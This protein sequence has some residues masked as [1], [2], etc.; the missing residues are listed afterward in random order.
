[1]NSQ[2]TQPPGRTW[3]SWRKRASAALFALSIA[4]V[5]WSQTVTI[6]AGVNAGTTGSNAGPIYRSSA[7]SA[8]DFSQQVYLYTAAELATA[9]ILPGTTITSLAW[10]KS[11]TF[12]TTATNTVSI[13]R[14]Y[15]KNS[16][17][18]PGATWS[19]TSFPTQVSGATLVYNNT[20]QVIPLVAGY[21]TLT[22][23]TPF[24]YTGGALEIGS[25][26]DCSLFA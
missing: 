1:M 16:A 22:F 7:G 11:N 21:I 20:A 4:L 13:W 24:V 9:G 10:N 3:R 17:A 25:D 26:W 5:G 23:G 12:G 2:N 8:F 19:S 15:M 6:G 14:V 18:T